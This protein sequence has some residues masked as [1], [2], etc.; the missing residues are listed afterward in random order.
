MPEL[1]RAR[2]RPL[3]GG[4]DTASAVHEKAEDWLGAK[5]QE[6]WL[7]DPQRKTASKCTW[8]VNAIIREPVDYL[9]TD[10][11]PGF[12]LSVHSLFER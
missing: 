2:C 10:L 8:S 6:V 7:I 9:S 12:E 11:L 1:P 3:C 4:L 5:C